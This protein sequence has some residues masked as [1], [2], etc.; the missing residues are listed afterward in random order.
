MAEPC[1]TRNGG[2]GNSNTC[3][4]GIA[5]VWAEVSARSASAVLSVPRAGAAGADGDDGA[6][7]E[8]QQAS[9]AQDSQAQTC[10]PGDLEAAAPATGRP[11]P[12][13]SRRLNKTVTAAFTM[14]IIG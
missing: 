2:M 9:P 4:R 12:H 13:T 5:G 14:R 8:Q 7:A 1:K 6:D 3:G 10:F 11:C